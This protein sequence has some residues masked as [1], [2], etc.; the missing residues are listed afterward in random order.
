[1]QSPKQY[2]DLQE[3]FMEEYVERVGESPI[4]AHELQLD[5]SNATAIVACLI[6]ILCKLENTSEAVVFYENLLLEF[7][8]AHNPGDFDVLWEDNDPWDE[9]SVMLWRNESVV[10]NE[11]LFWP[12]QSKFDPCDMDW[13]VS[14]PLDDVLKRVFEYIRLK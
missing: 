12:Q 4:L 13:E 1:M 9:W 14:L 7:E 3:I 2:D 6:S 10:F 8:N 11:S 5:E